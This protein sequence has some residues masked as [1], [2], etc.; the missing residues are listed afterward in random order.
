MSKPISIL[1]VDDHELIGK[2][3]STLLESEH[4]MQVD[5]SLSN[6]ED[7][8]Q[9]A[10]RLAPDVC[11]LDIDMPGQSCFDAGRSEKPHSTLSSAHRACSASPNF[12]TVSS[13]RVRISAKDGSSDR[14]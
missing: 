12:R 10:I 3:L 6:S 2:L 13:N 4:D 11:V 5:G 9:E 8:I 7:A 1:L 14:I